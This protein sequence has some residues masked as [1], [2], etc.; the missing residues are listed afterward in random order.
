VKLGLH[1]SNR[2]GREACERR[3]LGKIGFQP[4]VDYGDARVDLSKT[5]G[6]DRLGGAVPLVG[7]LGYSRSVNAIPFLPF[8][9]KGSEPLRREAVDHLDKSP[10]LPAQ[11]LNLTFPFSRQGLTDIVRATPGAALDH[12][13]T[14]PPEV[15][16]ARPI[17]L[18]KI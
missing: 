16:G 5:A 11:L 14:A 10:E 4:P 6:V 18:H 1:V 13:R 17:A 2:Q 7:R 15:G 9:D 3:I 12:A 8:R